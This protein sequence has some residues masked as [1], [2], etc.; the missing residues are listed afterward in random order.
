MCFSFS[1][2]DVSPIMLAVQCSEDGYPARVID[3]KDDD[4]DVSS[5]FIIALI[6]S[7]T[8]KHRHTLAAKEKSDANKYC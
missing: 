5:V 2:C 1:G 4:L 8:Q 3:S 7:I 6:N